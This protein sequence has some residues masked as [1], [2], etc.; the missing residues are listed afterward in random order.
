MNS[1]TDLERSVRKAVDGYF[2]DLDGEKAQGVYDM[3]INCVERP[4]IQAV[5]L[6]VEGNQTHAADVL[7]INRNTLRK[8][9]KTHGIKG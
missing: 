9:M 4:L 2:R 6:R 3:V 1:E 5:L 7:G 8:K